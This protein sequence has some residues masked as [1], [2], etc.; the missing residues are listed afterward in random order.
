MTAPVRPRARPLP[1]PTREGRPW[2]RPWSSSSPR[3]RP[4][5]SAGMLGPELRGRVL[6][7]PHPR[8]APRGRRGAGR[9]QGRG[10]GPPRGRRR[11]RLQAALRGLA[12]EE[13]GGGQ[14]QAPA[15]GG[16]RALP[17]H[18]RGPR[19][20]VHRLAPLRGALA[21]GPGQADGLPRDHPAGHRAG[22]WT[23]GGSSTAGWSTPRRP[24]GSSTASTAT[25]SRPVL[26][27]K[28]MPRLS[29]GRVQS[30]ATRMVVERERARMRFRSATW[31][32]VEGTFAGP[33]GE[34]AEATPRPASAPS[35]VALDGTPLATGRD[36]AETGEPGTPR[37]ASGC[38][39]RPRPGPW[40][41]AS[42]DRPVHRAVGDREAVPPLAGAAVH[43]LDPPAGGRPQAPLQRPA[44][45]AG[46]PAPLRAGLDHL[47]ADRLDHPVRRGPQ[48]RPV[49]GH[50]PLRAGV[51]ARRAPPLRAQGEERPGGPR[52][53]PA[54]RRHLPHPRRGRPRAAR[55]T[56][57]ASTS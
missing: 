5:P 32:G 16:R 8:P 40:P 45:H 30:V 27:K 38:S 2:V 23:S 11:Q 51:R 54:G 42:S 34:R 36:F 15:E 56:S 14:P 31:W 18:G 37:P 50:R 43:D 46:G 13:V 52:G 39:A 47:H 53:H 49:P 25:R 6:G 33:A 19:G 10:L 28:V 35:L 17:G 48:R 7:R 9:L 57:C 55:A 44:G 41:P 29:A 20:R 12:R 22:R 24:G 3:P 26:W 21:P 1:P 4:G